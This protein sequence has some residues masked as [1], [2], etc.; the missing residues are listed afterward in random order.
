MGAW[1]TW[2][3]GCTG[4]RG[5]SAP[6]TWRAVGAVVITLLAVS[7]GSD[8]NADQQTRNYFIAADEVA[9]NYAPVGTNLITGSPFDDTANKYVQAGP[10][11]ICSIHTKCLYHGYTDASSSHS[12][13]TLRQRRCAR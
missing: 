4:R 5:G 13:S 12:S 7:C 2:V 11:R 6:R 8:A 3:L 10:D 1:Q 9:W